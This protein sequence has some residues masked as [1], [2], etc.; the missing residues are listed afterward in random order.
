M[1]VCL[2]V[3][4]RVC[5]CVCTCV[6]MFSVFVLFIE[7][8]KARHINLLSET[9]I[10]IRP[11]THTK[12]RKNIYTYINSIKDETVIPQR[13]STRIKLFFSEKYL[14]IPLY[15]LFP[16]S[17]SHP[18]IFFSFPFDFQDSHQ[19]HAWQHAPL[20]L[21]KKISTLVNFSIWG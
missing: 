7:V 20:G 11:K 16:P 17:I 5:V 1:C 14:H 6:Y 9:Y 18:F 4:A 12:K 21:S 10:Q 2:C 15:L 19:I 8:Y 13:I 3:C